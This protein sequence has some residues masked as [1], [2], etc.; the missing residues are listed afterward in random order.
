M[1][2]YYDPNQQWQGFSGNPNYLNTNTAI[3]NTF[4]QQAMPQPQ[5]QQQS[6]RGRFVENPQSIT[7]QDVP[8][9]GSIGVYPTK[10]CSAIYLKAW[11]Q[12]G[13]IKTVKYIPEETVPEIKRKVTSLEDLEERVKKLEASIRKG[14]K[15]KEDTEDES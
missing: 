14:S 10:D 15:K 6:I 5:M 8:M 11:Q 3:P 12:D 4:R 13:T 7:P 1:N 2:G 9:D